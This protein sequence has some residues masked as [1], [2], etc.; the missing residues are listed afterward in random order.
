MGGVQQFVAPGEVGLAPELFDQ[1]AHPGATGM[2][3]HQASAGLIFDGEQIQIGADAAVVTALG[4]LDAVFVL[5]ELLRRF[6]GGAVNPLQLLAV[7]IAA[8]VGARHALQFEGF[9]IELAGV[10]HMGA[11]AEIPPLLP[12]GVEGDGLLQPF[13]DF[14]FVGLVLRFDPRFSFGAAHFN[15]LERQ[16]LVDDLDHRL[17]DGLEVGLGEGVGIIEVV[18]EARFGPGADGHAGVGEELLHRHGHHMAHGMANLEQLRAFAGLGKR[19]GG[20]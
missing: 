12:Q 8:P 4:F 18:I 14:E 5:A 10:L 6:K 11:G 15:P 17:L 16:L 9:G 19:H 1:Q 13:E 2:P 20:C 3:E 7:L